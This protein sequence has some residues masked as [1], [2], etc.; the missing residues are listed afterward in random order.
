M[1]QCCNRNTVCVQNVEELGLIKRNWRY[2]S[3]RSKNKIS[4]CFGSAHK[5]LCAE[6]VGEIKKKQVTTVKVVRKRNTI[7]SL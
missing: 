1:N 4:D 3:V 5:F 6:L 7:S 2:D